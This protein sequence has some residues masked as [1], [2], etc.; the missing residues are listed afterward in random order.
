M[1]TSVPKKKL[2]EYAKTIKRV[3]QQ[4]AKT[5]PDRIRTLIREEYPFFPEFAIELL[6]TDLQMGRVYFTVKDT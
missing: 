6:L 3:L 2:D 4:Q 1:T 5:D